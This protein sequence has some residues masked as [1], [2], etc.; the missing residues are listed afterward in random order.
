[1]GKEFFMPHRPLAPQLWRAKYLIVLEQPMDDIETLH[2]DQCFV[3]PR[4]DITFDATMGGNS[5][6]P[7][8]QDD[9]GLPEQDRGL[10][11]MWV[12]ANVMAFCGQEKGFLVVPNLIYHEDEDGKKVYALLMGELEA[13][14][15]DERKRLMESLNHDV[16]FITKDMW[17]IMDWKG[18]RKPQ[19]EAKEGERKRKLPTKPSDH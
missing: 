16:P 3:T 18:P 1:M 17:Y 5:L 11:K 15:K 10:Y 19:P 13:W 6:V 14:T 12:I 4:T 9:P 8:D 7:V 2:M